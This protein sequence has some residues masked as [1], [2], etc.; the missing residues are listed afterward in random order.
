MDK[1]YKSKMEEK[2]NNNIL[3]I[4]YVINC[5][6]KLENKINKLAYRE[7]QYRHSYQNNIKEELEYEIE[8]RKPFIEFLINK[9][10]LSMNEIKELIK[11]TKDKNK[12]TKKTCDRIREIIINDNYTIE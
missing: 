8:Y 6:A 5:V 2:I 4:E 10:C 3:T 12:P 1:S 9:Y 11:N 7:K